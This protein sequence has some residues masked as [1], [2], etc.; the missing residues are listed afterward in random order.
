MSREA[1]TADRSAEAGCVSAFAAKAAPAVS[2]ISA[3][4]VQSV[5]FFIITRLL[6]FFLLYLMFE[7]SLYLFSRA[8]ENYE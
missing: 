6:L 5:S 2:I 7:A 4:I 1:A 3:D 8:L